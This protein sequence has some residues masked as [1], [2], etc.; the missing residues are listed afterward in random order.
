ML[1][2]A[3]EESHWMYMM[4]GYRRRGCLC[5]DR[6]GK[7]EVVSSRSNGSEKKGLTASQFFVLFE[8]M[9]ILFICEA[10]MRDN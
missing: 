4:G 5:M 3:V 9:L 1:L 6:K 7:I 2:E 8:D 10:T